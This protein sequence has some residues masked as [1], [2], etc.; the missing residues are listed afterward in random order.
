METRRR[1]EGGGRDTG[2]ETFT[3]GLAQLLL[4]T[5]TGARHGEAY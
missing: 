3:R 5:P 1:E 2:I 4:V